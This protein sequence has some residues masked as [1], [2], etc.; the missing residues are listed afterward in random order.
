M[1]E[2]K[3]PLLRTRRMDA[4]RDVS[5]AA[6]ALAAHIEAGGE[7]PV[8]HHLEGSPFWQGALRAY[9]QLRDQP[10]ETVPC[11]CTIPEEWDEADLL[12][13]NPTCTHCQGSGAVEYWTPPIG[14]PTL[15]TPAPSTSP[16]SGPEMTMNA[17]DTATVELYPETQ[18]IATALNVSIPGALMALSEVQDAQHRQPTATPEQIAAATGLRLNAVQAV[19]AAQEN[20][21]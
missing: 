11:D 18:A 3:N 8:G 12:P 14:T 13:P 6:L 1:N 4:L 9:E 5:A 21:K 19:L 15:L 20:R 17:F 10:F 2:L 16:R 7:V